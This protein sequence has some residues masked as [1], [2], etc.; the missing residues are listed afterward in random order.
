ML[1]W[2]WVDEHSTMHMSYAVPQYTPSR[3]STSLHCTG[4]YT[5]SRKVQYSLELPYIF[6]LQPRSDVFSTHVF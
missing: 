5:P 6:D 3:E 4:A 2:I 1:H